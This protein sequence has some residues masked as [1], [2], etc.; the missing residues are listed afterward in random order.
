[1]IRPET[2]EDAA[3]VRA[4]HVAAFAPSTVEAEILDALRAAGDLVPALTLVAEREGAIA[5]HVAISRA[6]VEDVE[7][8][9]LGPIGVLPAL[10]HAGI[11]AALMRATLAAAA[12]TSYP[13]VA[14]LGHADY[15]PRFGFESADA[16][17]MT[18][19]YPVR[20]GVLDGVPAAGVRPVGARRVP[21]RRRVRAGELNS[22]H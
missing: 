15:Y 9:A 18:C 21:L 5:G 13:L 6:W 14:L 3:A 12:G 10:Q 2:P 19:P 20:A 17:G 7:V 16:L 1:M 11:G 22:T 8:L 4:L